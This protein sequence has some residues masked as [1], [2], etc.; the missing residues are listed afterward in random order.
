MNGQICKN[1]VL[2]ELQ[3]MRKIVNGRG[4]ISSVPSLMTRATKGT[5][6]SRQ[7]GG[8]EG[9]ASGRAGESSFRLKLHDH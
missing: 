4:I 8:D 3:V 7:S 9:T 5:Y 2:A 1:K 6:E